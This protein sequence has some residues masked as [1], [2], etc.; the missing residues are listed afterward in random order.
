MRTSQAGWHTAWTDRGSLDVH[1]HCSLSNFASSTR[2]PEPAIK[3]KCSTAQARCESACMH[4]AILCCVHLTKIALPCL[5]ARGLGWTAAPCISFVS[6]LRYIP[7]HTVK[8]IC[9]TAACCSTRAA[10]EAH[11]RDS[12]GRSAERPET[13]RAEGQGVRRDL[14]QSR[15]SS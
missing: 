6:C 14:P 11:R 10:L 9:R 2:P 15:T 8:A 5:D 3:T 12:A 13:Q 1:E 7:F 4:N